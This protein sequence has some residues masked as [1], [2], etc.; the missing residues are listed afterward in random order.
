MNAWPIGI[1][2]ALL[3]PL[4]A[5]AAPRTRI[6]QGYVI[7][8]WSTEDG[9][10][11]NDVHSLGQDRDG[12][13]WIGTTAGLMRFDG[14]E[15]KPW[16][17]LPGQESA[18]STVW[19]L[20]PLPAGGMLVCGD[21][22]GRGIFR[23]PGN[24]LPAPVERLPGSPEL[25]FRSL[26]L[27]RNQVVWASRWDEAW[28]RCEGGQTE[29]V[30]EMGKGTTSLPSSFASTVD[31]GVF[32]GRGKGVEEWSREQGLR[33]LPGL[34]SGPVTFCAAREGGLWVADASA[35]YRWRDEKA[36]RVARIE[37]NPLDPPP[38]TMLETA[39]GE[40]WIATKSTG[41]RCWRADRLIS[42]NIPHP[43][44]RCLQEDDEGNLWAGTAGGGLCQLRKTAFDRAGENAADTIGSFCQDARGVRWIVNS[45]GIWHLMG[46]HAVPAFPA[47]T[48][49]HEAQAVC[50]DLDGNVWIGT[51]SGLYLCRA[52][53]P[54][55]PEP[56]R[57]APVPPASTLALFCDRDGGMWAGFVSGPV[58]RLGR[59][60]S[61][62]F[63]PE[64]GYHGTYA[65]AFGQD[66]K[67]N[68]WIG[69][70][71][72][73][74]YRFAQGRFQL[75]DP[76]LAQ[77][78]RG[79]LSIHGDEEGNVWIG[80]AGQGLLVHRHDRFILLGRE[81]GL[82]DA[83]LPQLLDDG[84]G[85]LWFGTS[86]MIFSAAKADLLAC[87]DGVRRTTPTTTYGSDDGV[88]LFYAAG[89]RQP[90][91]WKTQD[92]RLNFLGR[93]GLVVHEPSPAKPARPAPG[94]FIDGVWLDEQEVASAGPLEVPAHVQSVRIHFTV[95]S[96]RHSN[97]IR[98]R[99]RLKG[100]DAEWTDNS[101]QR[102]VIYPRPAPGRHRFEVAAANARSGWQAVPG[103]LVFHVHP[104]WWERT[105]LRVAGA[106]VAAL[107]LG[108]AVRA[109]TQRRL[110][111]RMLA[112]DQE[113]RVEQERARIAR[114]LHDGLGA[115][116]TEAGLLAAE[117][118]QDAAQGVDTRP[119]TVQLG[120]RIHA[121]ARE[122]DEAVWAVS[123][124]HDNLKSLC[125]YLCDYAL[126]H[127]RHSPVRCLLEVDGHFPD[128]SIAP[129]VR[130]QLFMVVKE[131]LNNVIKHA[132]ATNARLSIRILGRTL[133]IRISDDG[134]S[135]DP[136]AGD[137]SRR[138]GF[139]NMKER[140]EEVGGAWSFEAQPGH[141]TTVRI[142]L[143]LQMRSGPPARPG[144]M[145]LEAGS[146][147]G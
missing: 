89:Q 92:G 60:G 30:G 27:D 137:H 100:A 20:L 35:L 135:F 97:E 3:L 117:L 55:V 17:L 2:A 104:F 87:V 95:P 57:A 126:E 129:H 96:L 131:S 25:L 36:E 44:V 72:G 119:Q 45:I 26:H 47:D 130:H 58:L 127:F 34:P 85:H 59:G 121:L 82:P 50:P 71:S 99:Y 8:E 146:P 16:P 136:S 110:R 76:G 108:L 115:G 116:L 14:V 101:S 54:E 128:A 125:G 13:L 7:R 138:S 90:C 65:Q 52:E 114:D 21:E 111:A 42:V 15:F 41:L 22:P 141:G 5:T 112:I 139:K 33:S 74:V 28:M 1:F 145:N 142:T 38:F 102:F 39:A 80:T 140:M 94:V 69:T 86:R 48:V 51:S 12:F 93:K 77:P 84:L 98:F 143:P 132:R 109:G 120:D 91:A 40:V 75:V 18:K 56:F 37:G 29:V 78:L 147:A 103:T 49:P 32:I 19:S 70:R 63:G 133:H 64:Q 11:D 43:V 123:P 31:G 124:R 81:N 83:H 53:S 134:V 144:N 79:V 62:S 10:I 23:L 46:K 88:S 24:L 106:L 113:N 73:E 9:L 68:V 66:R 6:H 4:A 67:G 107:G 118:R 122:L 61:E 105:S